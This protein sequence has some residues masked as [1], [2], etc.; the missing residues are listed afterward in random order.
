VISGNSGAG[1]STL[2]KKLASEFELCGY[3]YS[4]ADEQSFHHPL[5]LNM[6]HEP[7]V[8]AYPIQLNFILQR[9][10]RLRQEETSPDPPAFLL[11]ERCLWEDELFFQYYLRNGAIPENFEDGYHKVSQ[12]MISTTIRPDIIIHLRTTVEGSCNRLEAAFGSGER[13]VEISGPALQRY[14]TGMHE[15]YNKWATVAPE[16]C[17]VYQEYH[18]DSQ[19]FSREE[20]LEHIKLQVLEGG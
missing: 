11:M 12:S 9:F 19:G 18:V 14:I 2:L 10:L 1:K 6:F 13:Q 4:L 8:W 5:L 7:R 20:M 17:T 16:F 15:L 3:T